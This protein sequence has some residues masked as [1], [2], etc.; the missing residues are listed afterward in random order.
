MCLF[1]KC[2]IL[3]YLFIGLHILMKFQEDQMFALIL[4]TLTVVLEIVYTCTCKEIKNSTCSVH[5]IRIL[6]VS[7]I[8]FLQEQLIVDW[9]KYIVRVTLFYGVSKIDPSVAFFFWLYDISVL[10]DRFQKIRHH[11]S[12]KHFRRLKGNSPSLCLFSYPSISPL[13]LCCVR[14]LLV[15]T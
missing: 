4:S 2:F 11:G 7:T 10:R 9:T 3:I 12:T 13:S 5:C 8:F 1:I 14:R 15:K 6:N